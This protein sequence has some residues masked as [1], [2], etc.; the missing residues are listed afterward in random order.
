MESCKKTSLGIRHSLVSGGSSNTPST[1]SGMSGVECR[2]TKDLGRLS[3]GI[4]RCVVVTGHD[5]TVTHRNIIGRSNV[6]PYFRGP[7]CFPR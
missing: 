6:A 5:G 1:S 2:G 7:P 3:K 4:N